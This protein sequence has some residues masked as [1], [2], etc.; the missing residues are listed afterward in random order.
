V[1]LLAA[2]SSTSRPAAF[3]AGKPP[4]SSATLHTRKI[5][6]RPT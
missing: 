5:R 4:S 1:S 2:D 3:H 6:Q